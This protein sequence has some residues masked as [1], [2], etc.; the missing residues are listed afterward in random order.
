MHLDFGEEV[1]F[2]EKTVE[3]RF[4]TL[5]FLSTLG[6]SLSEEL[7]TWKIK[8][9][10]KLKSILIYN[11]LLIRVGNSKSYLDS[12]EKHKRF[13][14]KYYITMLKSIQSSNSTKT[15]IKFKSRTPSCS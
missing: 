13:N 12:K 14:I 11:F 2:E 8:A 9:S 6:L 5:K 10:L 1:F 15:G 7:K 3:G 4:M